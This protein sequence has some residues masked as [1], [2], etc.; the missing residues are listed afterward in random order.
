MNMK[1][2]HHKLSFNMYEGEFDFLSHV[3]SFFYSKSWFAQ[4]L[5]RLEAQCRNGMIPKWVRFLKLRIDREPFGRGIMDAN[6][7]SGHLFL[8]FAPYLHAE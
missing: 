7:R 5:C 6:L 1:F 3:G 4:N 2:F 8:L